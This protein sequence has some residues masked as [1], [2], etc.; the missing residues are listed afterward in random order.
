[1]AGFA[2]MDIEK[3]KTGGELTSKFIHN[4]RK[5][6]IDNVIPEMSNQNEVLVSLPQQSGKTLNYNEAFKERINSLPYYENHKIRSNAVLGYEVLLTFTRDPSIDLNQWKNQ[7]MKWLHDTFDVAPDGKSNV[8]HAELHM[9]EVGNPHI[10]AFVVPI[11]ERGRL[12]AK[13]FTNGSRVMSALQTSYADAVKSTGLKR[14]VAGSSAKHQDIRKMYANLNNAMVLPDIKKG[15]TAEE[16]KNRI[17]EQAK[18]AYARG[19]REVD[20]YSVKTRRKMDEQKNM[21]HRAIE[22]ELKRAKKE[23]EHEIKKMEQKKGELEEH[24]MSYDD[25]IELMLE[26]MSVVKKQLQERQV[27]L[28][29]QLD[30]E[31]AKIFYDN[32][33]TGLDELYKQDAER[34][35]SFQNEMEYIQEL[36]QM[37]RDM[38]KHYK[39]QE[40]GEIDDIDEIG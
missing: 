27:E 19:K 33:Q 35:E 25:M 36:G 34:A 24:I 26:Q 37:Q 4:C 15:E 14:G 12:N 17:A 7:S 5:I 20:D 32:L 8:L 22:L 2:F 40:S 11:D 1:M 30:R 39:E 38:Q 16:Y 29:E 10:H 31:N 13:R 18:T 6:Q 23:T 3:I 9:D 21:E 28:D